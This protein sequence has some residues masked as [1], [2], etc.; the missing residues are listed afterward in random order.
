MTPNWPLWVFTAIYLLIIIFTMITLDHLDPYDDRL[1]AIVFTPTLI[2][3]FTILQSLVIEP[4]QEKN[5]RYAKVIP[6]ALIM[7]W[8]IYPVFS[9][10]KQV[11]ITRQ[12]GVQTY[13]VYNKPFFLDELVANHLRD[14]PLQPGVPVY[15]NDPEAAYL[16]TRQVIRYSPQDL[17][18]PSRTLSYLQTQYKD[19][20]GTNLA[21]LIW[22]VEYRQL[23]DFFTPEE[24][25]EVADIEILVQS[26]KAGGVYLIRPHSAGE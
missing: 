16:L 24:L 20:P 22:F 21:Y 14:H 7:I 25:G 5:L 9:I 18:N 6:V 11:T 10:W 17:K 4:L 23:R 19:W 1:I 15:S 26:K 13:N 2:F 8:L 3:L 12:K